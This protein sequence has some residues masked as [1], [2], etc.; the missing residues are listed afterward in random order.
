MLLAR[1]WWA[2]AIRGLIAIIFGVIAIFFPATAFL[3]LVLVFGIFVL[4]DGIFSIVAVFV[5]G[6]HSESWWWLVIEGAFGI[7]IG[8]LTLI[9]PA[10]MAFAWIFVIA[11]WA[12]VTG[13]LEIFTAIRLRKTIANEGWMIVSGV[14]SVL[15]GI[16]VTI[17]PQSGAFAIGLIIGIYALMFGITLLMI[18]FRLRKHAH[19]PSADTA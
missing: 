16:L 15:F 8:I 13:I 18:A 19:R 12:L 1:N 2:F 3:S 7:L 4:V 14:L 6:A 5:S 10:A 9:Q 17:S 11:A